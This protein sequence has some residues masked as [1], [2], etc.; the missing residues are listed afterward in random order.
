MTTLQASDIASRFLDALSRRDFDG[1]AATFKEGGRLRGLVPSAL[2]EAEGRE[3]IAERF[4][5]WNDAEDWELIE[6]DTT[7]L[8]DVVK[9]R[10]RIA[11]SDPEAGR[12]VYEQTA[13]AEIDEGGIAWMNLV[14][15]GE[16]SVS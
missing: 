9:L 2:R 8:A 13:Y 7:E 5:I 12:T 15:S 16:R 3:A 10:W 1:L 6:S 4:G 14:C 11:S